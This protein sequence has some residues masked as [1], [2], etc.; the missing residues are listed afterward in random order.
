MEDCLKRL[1]AAGF[2]HAGRWAR[3]GD[4][5]SFT[6]YAPEEPGVYVFVV[7]GRVHYVGAAQ[8]GI[9][10]R[11]RSY[12]RKQRR[13]QERPDPRPVHR[14]LFDTIAAG[15]KV[16]V[17]VLA[18]DQHTWRDLP[19]NLTAGIEEGVIKV[20]NPP[21]NVRGRTMADAA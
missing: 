7:R 13:F 16:D 4:G 5:V 11:L 14:H 12:H 10:R 20:F 3:S 15:D 6:C 19:I 9:A 1:H 8:R 2:R 21:W 18:P 17:F